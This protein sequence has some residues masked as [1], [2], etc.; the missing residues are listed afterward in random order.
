LDYVHYNPV[1]HGFVTK[2]IDW[3]HSSF[4]MAVNQGLYKRDWGSNE[5]VTIVDMGFE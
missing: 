4:E 1:K 2:P 5:P 3:P